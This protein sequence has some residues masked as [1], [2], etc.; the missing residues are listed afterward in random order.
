MCKKIVSLLL[1]ISILLACFSSTVVATS[2]ENNDNSRIVQIGYQAL[3]MQGNT[4][5]ESDCVIFRNGLLNSGYNY[6][7]VAANGWD[8][9]K[10]DQTEEFESLQRVTEGQFQKIGYYD[11]AYYSGHGG[12]LDVN[13]EIHPVIN[14]TP[15]KVENDHGVS[16]PIDVADALSVNTSNWKSTCLVTQDSKLSVLILSACDQLDSSIVKYYARLMRASGVRVVAGYHAAAPGTGIDDEIARE[17]INLASEGNS[18][19]YSWKYANNC[20]QN[21]AVLVYEDNYNQYYRL[22]GFPG[23]TYSAPSSTAAVYRYADF[24]GDGKREAST[25]SLNDELSSQ[26]LLLPLTIT[27]SESNIS[28]YS[29]SSD[30][31]T[32]LSDVTYL[33]EATVSNELSD[34]LGV[35]LS[36]RICVDHYITREQVDEDY[37]LLEET[38]TVVERI[39]D[40]H[41]TYLGIKI[42]DSFIRACVDGGG[43]HNISVKAQNVVSTGESLSD[44]SRSRSVSYLSQEEAL[45]IARNADASSDDFELYNIALAYAPTDNG[46]H[47]L[48]YEVKTSHGFFYVDVLTGE[49]I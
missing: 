12:K 29:L 2:T 28:T 35:D 34:T 44:T 19:W 49:L 15:S 3:V 27:T 17:F 26:L 32:E 42:V 48:C 41:D 1:M 8:P 25:A 37:G 38:A 36:D 24:L 45:S 6:T 31:E 33:E 4:E 30:R 47:V 5:S 22:P 21:W 9:T 11:V 10:I 20:G 18:I 46:L 13:G 16:A 23:N 39:Y 43:M 7:L 14:F 40:Y